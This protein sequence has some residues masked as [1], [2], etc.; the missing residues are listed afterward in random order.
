[1]IS[2]SDRQLERISL[3]EAKDMKVKSQV[4][5]SICVVKREIFAAQKLV[6]QVYLILT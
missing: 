6:L 4:I 3:E 5:S 2:I 1:M